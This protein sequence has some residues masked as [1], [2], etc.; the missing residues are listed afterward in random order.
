VSVLRIPGKDTGFLGID[1][2][3][4]HAATRSAAEVGVGPEVIRFVEP[5]GCLVT[6]VIAGGALS[7][8]EMRRPEN[9]R[10]LALRHVH[11]GQPV[12]TRFDVSRVV[13]A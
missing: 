4:E 8:E 3:A 2:A 11:G 7:H 6:R 10:R 12:P 9:I 13:E 1:R 5:E